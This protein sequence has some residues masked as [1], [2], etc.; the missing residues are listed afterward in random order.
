MVLEQ[1]ALCGRIVSLSRQGVLADW[2]YAVPISEPTVPNS[3]TVTR[4][5]AGKLSPHNPP[6]SPVEV[7]SQTL[8]NSTKSTNYVPVLHVASEDTLPWLTP[9]PE[10]TEEDNIV[11]SMGASK[12]ENS[13]PLIN[14]SPLYCM[15]TWSWM[16][17]QLVMAGPRQLVKH[18]PS[19]DLESIFYVLVGIFILLDEPYKPKCDTDLAQCFNKYFNTFEP[20]V[21]K[22]ITI[23]SNITW[24]PFIMRHI[25][26][27]FSP[28]INL[29]TY[30]C[31][32]L[33][34]PMSMDIADNFHH[35]TPFTHDIFID[36]LINTLSHLKP[37]AWEPHRR[38]EDD[39]FVGQEAYNS[40][41]VKSDTTENI[42]NAIPDVELSD[43]SVESDASTPPTDSADEPSDESKS[44][45]SEKGAPLLT[46]PRPY[47][48]QMSGGPGFYSLDSGLTAHC[49]REESLSEGKSNKHWHKS[50]CGGFP[51]NTRNSPPLPSRMLAGKVK[52]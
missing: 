30:L 9:V 16:A 5:L 22:T 13:H 8:S 51:S 21:L 2:G 11:L 31:S 34:S 49:P 43:D 46:L 29:L 26:L 3:E 18:K 38:P 37:D 28:A 23:Q 20:N 44:T 25:S 39:E 40:C 41:N 15:G 42:I 10:L 50:S 19:H 1:E 12:E 6:T 36:A 14:S 45:S 47:P 7:P 52:G 48:C 4:R 17:A 24:M 32:T 27:Y 33:I 35:E